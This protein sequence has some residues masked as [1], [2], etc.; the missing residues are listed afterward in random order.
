MSI[1]IDTKIYNSYKKKW[2]DNQKPWRQ[3][4]KDPSFR[5][6][7][8]NCIKVKIKVKNMNLNGPLSEER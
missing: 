7:I 4:L 3:L 6:F 8:Q 5:K 2:A 1:N